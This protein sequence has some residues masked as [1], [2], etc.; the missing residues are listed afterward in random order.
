MCKGALF[1][2]LSH[3]FKGP[4]SVQPPFC[5]GRA[6]TKNAERLEED[7][8]D[9]LRE[10]LQNWEPEAGVMKHARV[11]TK[12]N[13]P[14]QKLPF[15]FLCDNHNHSVCSRFCLHYLLLSVLSI[16]IWCGS[17]FRQQRAHISFPFKIKY[18]GELFGKKQYL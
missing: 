9:I 18:I 17:V 5:L 11:I 4:S 8:Q 15:H 1:S 16:S 12:L 7:K 2:Q 3:S 14:S 13:C 6:W 10:Q